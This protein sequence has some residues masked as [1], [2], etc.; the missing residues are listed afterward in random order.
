MVYLLFYQYNSNCCCC[1]IQNSEWIIVTSS[2]RS[3]L[4]LYVC[5]SP[6]FLYHN[7]NNTI[8][9]YRGYNKA[10]LTYNVKLAVTS[11]DINSKGL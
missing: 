10:L 6:H 9:L 3:P 1:G 11:C 7:N 2:S 4:N 8:Y 5:A